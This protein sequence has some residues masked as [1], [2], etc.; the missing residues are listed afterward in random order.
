MK[1]LSVKQAT[2][3]I[4]LY[5]TTT[6]C[7]SMTT[8]TSD[9]RR[10][11]KM[12][13]EMSIHQLQNM[14]DHLEAITGIVEAMATKDYKQ[15]ELESKRLASSPQ[16]K[17]MCSHMGKATPGFTQMGL[18]LHQT[19]DKLVHA[20]KKKNYDQFV[21]LLGRTLKTCTSCHSSFK[22]EIVTQDILHNS[23]MK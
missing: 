9:K 12:T 22:Q 21:T 7:W 4:L 13:K 17:M 6:Q 16:M 11:L 1:L 5:L 14:R 2:L 15:M 18:A 20:A 19:A 10:A 8:S 3:F 23:M